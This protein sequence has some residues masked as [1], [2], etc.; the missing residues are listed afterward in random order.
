MIHL[1]TKNSTTNCHHCN[2]QCIYGQ[3]EKAKYNPRLPTS[4][5]D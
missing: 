3:K 2:C 1:T 4:K 5:D